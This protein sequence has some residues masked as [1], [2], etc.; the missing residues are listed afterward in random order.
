MAKW[1]AFVLMQLAVYLADQ[2]PHRDRS[3]GITR[4]TQCLLG[5]LH[6]LRPEWQFACIESNSSATSGLG[7]AQRVLLPFATD[8]RLGRLV[9][10][11]LH[12]YLVSRTLQPDLWYYPKGFLP[13]GPRRKG[14]RVITVHDTILAHYAEKYPGERSAVDYAYWLGMLEHSLRRADCVL[15]VS[16]TARRQ[17]ETFAQHRGIKLGRIS[18]T[19][20]ASEFE[21]ADPPAWSSKG[22]YVVHC[23]SPAPHK[24]TQRLLEWWAEIQSQGKALP[25][26]KLTG[27]GNET[28]RKIASTLHHVEWL[29]HLDD[30]D[31]FDT[32][33][34]ARALLMPS[35]IEG[36]GLPALEACLMGTPVCYVEGT[37]IDEIMGPMLPQ[38]RFSLQDGRS[39]FGALT[40]VLGMDA[41]KMMLARESLRAS[42]SKK[43]FAERTAAAFLQT[44]NRA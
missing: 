11:H 20:E 32:I 13:R 10:D 42:Y 2:N 44:V 41:D 17:I 21:D 16:E 7:A 1:L 25:V 29:G 31:Y 23:A 4:M 39:F 43:Q 19:Y 28:A 12:P 27:K 30:T 8:G 3:L 34:H 40:Q 37:S 14:P 36:F 5:A 18:V 6:A 22:D 26:L 15:T 38:G 24:H 35:E 9:A 33:G